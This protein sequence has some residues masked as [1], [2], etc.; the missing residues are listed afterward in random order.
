MDQGP[1]ERLLQSPIVQWTGMRLLAHGPD[2]VEVE[3]PARAEFV[4]A[5]G[6]LHGGM[7][8]MLADS[9][10]VFLL[11][12]A[13]GEQRRMTSIEFKLNFLGAARPGAQP[14][15]ARSRT[16]RLG[17]QVAVCQTEVHQGEV[18]V[19]TGLFTYLLGPRSR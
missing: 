6:V 1:Y 14:L 5:E 15:V 7:L 16:L 2:C 4:Q 10:A 19:C 17:R 11:W 3:L 13:L 9:A 18:H 12:P 8:A